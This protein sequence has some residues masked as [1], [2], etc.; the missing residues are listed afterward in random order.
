MNSRSHLSTRTAGFSLVEIVI[1]LVLIVILAGISFPKLGGLTARNRINT[2]MNQFSAD[3]AYAR[4]LAVQTGDGARIQIRS[5]PAGYSLE[6]LRDGVW[7]EAKR[8]EIAAEYPGFSMGPATTLSF[9][10]RGILVPSNSVTVRV[11]QHQQRDSVFV[12][13]TG[14]VYR[15]Y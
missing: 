2:V 13:P 10:S 1:A 8:V 12:L 7:Q 15:G 6:I 14:R 3:V 9:N 5:A 4:A 11:E